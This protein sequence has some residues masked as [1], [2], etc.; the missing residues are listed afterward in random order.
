MSENEIEPMQ[1]GKAQG[2][3]GEYYWVSLAITASNRYTDINTQAK[4]WCTEQ[5]G[6]S[7]HR[8]FEK[9]QKFYFKNERDMTMFILRWS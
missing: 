9:K 3:I 8:W 1:T 6:S 4:D 5:F 7:G 2:W